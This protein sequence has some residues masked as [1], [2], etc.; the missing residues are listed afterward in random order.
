MQIKI[1]SKRACAAASMLSQFPQVVVNY[2]AGAARADAVVAEL[3]AA[4]GD[5]VAIGGNVGKVRSGPHVSGL[6]RTEHTW[7]SPHLECTSCSS[8]QREEVAE[9]FKKAVEAFGRVDI[10]VNNA[11]EQRWIWRGAAPCPQILNLRVHRAPLMRS[12]RRA[13]FEIVLSC[14]VRAPGITRD[15]LLMRMK[16]EQWQE[17]IDVNLSGVFYCTQ[18]RLA[19]EDPTAGSI[20]AQ[21]SRALLWRSF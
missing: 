10:L 8:L 18:V 9:L 11:G 5:A 2:A 17:V 1:P 6:G 13:P 15:T 12:I 3:K 20:E 19:V 4:G 21:R 7:H 16:P 14:T